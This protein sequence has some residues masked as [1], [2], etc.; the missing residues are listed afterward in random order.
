MLLIFA[1]ISIQA[2]TVCRNETVYVN[3]NSS[4]KPLKTE[5]VTWLRT[6]GASLSTDIT[7][8]EGLKNIKSEIAPVKSGAVY[9]FKTSEKDIFYSGTTPSALPVAVNL[10]YFLNGRKVDPSSIKGKSGVL[11]ITITITNRTTVP[12]TLTYR[13]IGT[14]YVKKMRTT[15][16]VPFMVMVSTDLPIERFGN[17]DAPEGAFAV[18][19][20]I[21][22][23]NWLAFPYPAETVTLKAN[24]TDF[25]TPSFMFTVIPKMPPLPKVDVEG[26]MN[27]IYSGVDQVGA[28][29]KQ[30]QAGALE[31]N[32]GHKKLKDAT[33]LVEEGTSKL[34]LA[35]DA[36][37]ELAGGAL[38]INRGLYENMQKLKKVP[39]MS[40][41]AD[42]ALDYL[43][44]QSK[45]LNLLIMGGPFPDDVL[46]FLIKHGKPEPPVKEFPGIKVTRQGISE[47]N[48]GASMM[49]SGASQL[50]EGS[51]KLENALIQI[52]QQGTEKLKQGIREGAEPLMR[53]LAKVDIGYIL[54]QKYDRFTGMP[55]SVKSS[56]EF[57]MKTPD[58]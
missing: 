49:S 46:S 2:K 4:G 24:V 56:V 7:S 25:K 30:A 33:I 38:T 29:L 57:I 32:D 6:D 1:P 34:L 42:Q 43:D 12:S 17:I 37:S 51:G 50:L 44:M 54:A 27:K 15:A 26:R 55:S 47:L 22:K 31:I 36:Q 45:F 48:K 10:S 39:F 13:E 28:Y 9:T 20:N 53:Q 3:L 16:S 41:K 21:I 40:K 8:I 18:I 23:M 5:V 11:K 58:E 14:G 19:G 52:R 35:S